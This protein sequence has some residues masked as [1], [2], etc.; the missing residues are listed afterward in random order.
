MKLRRFLAISMGANLL[1]AC[2]TPLPPP[3]AHDCSVGT[4]AN[5]LDA[6][7]VQGEAPDAALLDTSVLSPDARPSNFDA[8]QGNADAE[9][10]DSGFLDAAYPDAQAIDAGTSGCQGHPLCDDFETDSVG[11]PPGTGRWTVVSPNCSGSATIEVDNSQAHSGS[12][13]VRVSGPGGYCNHVFI[14]PM[15]SVDALGARIFGRFYVRFED[16]LN[17]EHVTFLTLKDQNQNKDIRMGGQSQILMWNRETD[18]ATLPELSPTGISMSLQPAPSTW[19]CIEF[20]IDE[21]AGELETWVDGQ[22]VP[23]LVIDAT[24]T[25]DVDA[26]WHRM[27]AWRPN[28]VNVRFGWESYGSRRAAL[29][30]DDI[31]LG[32]SRIGCQ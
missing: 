5:A 2:T 10:R 23:G 13:S 8:G 22:L 27:G 11:S 31:A 16:A 6:G 29:W 24:A 9:S 15:T 1:L 28:L 14:E 12:K 20:S 7:L 19:I 25:Q 17:Y 26:Q 3:L 21:A 30:F 18:D 4:E 32:T